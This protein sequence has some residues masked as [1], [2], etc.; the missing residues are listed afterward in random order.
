MRNVIPSARQ[1]QTMNL[2]LSQERAIQIRKLADT[3][4]S[5]FADAIARLIR[6]AVAAGEISGTVPGYEIEPQEDGNFR[7]FLKGNLLAPFNKAQLHAFAALI[8]DVLETGE[9]TISLDLSE[10]IEVLRH[11]K[12]LR[13]NVLRAGTARINVSAPVSVAQDFAADLYR[14]A[15]K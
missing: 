1:I 12:V 3:Y 9:A 14:H 10:P 4:N 15:E 2:A 5:S 11:G 7:V 6:H 8:E 13:F